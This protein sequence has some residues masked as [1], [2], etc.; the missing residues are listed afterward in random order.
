MSR[1][2]TQMQKL[3][4][5]VFNLTQQ[6]LFLHGLVEGLRNER[7]EQPK[8]RNPEACCGNC[9]YCGRLEGDVVCCKD[10]CS[11]DTICGYFCSHHPDFWRTKKGTPEQQTEQVM[12][13][14]T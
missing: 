11:V 8:E 3:E 4:E 10:T 9:P 5:R 7:P 13:G 6:N 12:E 2:K 1:E 14:R